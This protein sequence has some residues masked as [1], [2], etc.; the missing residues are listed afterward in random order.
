M[1]IRNGLNRWRKLSDSGNGLMVFTMVAYVL[2]SACSP[3]YYVPNQAHIPSLGK[4]GEA[5]FSASFAAPILMDV[6][7]VYGAQLSWSPINHIGIAADGFVAGSGSSVSDDYTGNGKGGTVSLGFYAMA[8][9]SW[10]IECYAGAGSGNVQL[11]HYSSKYFQSN[12][13]RYYVQP[14]IF[15]RSWHFDFGLAFRLSNVQYTNRKYYQSPDYSDVLYD[16]NY[17]FYEPSAYVALGGNIVKARFQITPSFKIDQ[18]KDFNRE[19]VILGFGVDFMI[20]RKSN[21]LK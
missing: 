4:A 5:K 11:N 7:H 19:K 21:Q 12:I 16:N 8:N 10:G 6:N 17:L 1:L 3:I 18:H 15:F 13:Q 20:N 14:A 9:S 2:L